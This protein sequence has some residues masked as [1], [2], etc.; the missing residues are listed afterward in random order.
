MQGALVGEEVTVAIKKRMPK[1]IDARVHQIIKPSALRQTPPCPVFSRCGG[2]SVQYMSAEE[3]VA[4]KQDA[5]LSQ[6]SRW[7]QITPDTLLPVLTDTE[8]GYR[9]RV[10]LAVDYTKTGELLLGF[11]EVDSRAIVNIDSC[12]VLN[13][14]LQKLIH[15]LR[16]WLSYIKAHVVSHVEL[17]NTTHSAA[18]AS[19]DGTE[20]VGI[21]VR[22][23]RLLASADRLQLQQCMSTFKK[24]GL[25]V[26]LW[27]QSQKKGVLEDSNNIEVDP[28]LEYVL[29]LASPLLFRF[30]PQ[31]FIQS[32]PSINQKMVEQAIA[33][34]APQS[35]EIV[36]DLYCGIGNFSLP[37]ALHAK[38]VL[39][40]EGVEA[41][42]IRAAD[43]AHCNG[44]NNVTF[45]TQDL[46]QPKLLRAS[47]S[48]YCQKQ[49]AF[50]SAAQPITQSITSTAQ[51]DSSTKKPAKQGVIDALLLDPP[52][53]GAKTICENIAE[54][55]PQRI[56]YVS[57][58]SSTFARDA[59]LLV[60]NGYRLSTLGIMDMFPQTSHVEIM[61]SF[62]VDSATADPSL[63]RRKA[64]S[65]SS[66]SVTKQSV[67]KPKR[68]LKLG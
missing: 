55:L 3:Q 8:Y 42:T 10:R 53:A 11:R 26:N 49:D 54:L 28:R 12:M 67:T 30:H 38:H 9:Q 62:I 23:T 44:I 13:P 40:V 15:P 46:S 63:K 57:C 20:A 45:I 6:L 14:N 48:A 52:R 17:V 33:L 64:S 29:P 32:N 16:Q 68:V 41:M 58:D 37:L 34:L 18:P 21:V 56:V 31:D 25:T 4:F 50:Q 22:H 43:N 51:V 61:A 35:H 59:G 2:C 47:V 66:Q 65:R 60:D 19:G 7:S 27:F 24:A 39:A 5:V 36:M 1:Y